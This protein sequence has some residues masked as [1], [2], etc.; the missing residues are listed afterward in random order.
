[1]G[2]IELE[3][4]AKKKKDLFYDWIG[5]T[6]NKAADVIEERGHTK[7]ALQD[8][9][10][11]VCL[12]GAINLALSG[13]ATSFSVKVSNTQHQ[14]ASR[15]GFQSASSAIDWNNRNW[16]TQEEVINRLREAARKEV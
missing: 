6:L 8:S 5:E 11:R 10:G 13:S 2:I 9:Q 16:R 12:Y 4:P 7:Y 15:L 1:M 14:F 3:K